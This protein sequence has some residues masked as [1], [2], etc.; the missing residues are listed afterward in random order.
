MDKYTLDKGV[1][2]IIPCL[3][4]E[5]YIEGLLK[6]LLKTSKNNEIIILDGGSQD[7]TLSILSR[8]KKRITIHQPRLTIVN[9]PKKTQASAINLGLLYVKNEICFRLDSHSMILNHSQL[10]ANISEIINIL[11]HK[12]DFCAIGFKQ[13]F[14]FENVIQASLFLLSL[15]P[16][17]SSTRSYRYAL[18]KCS[19][20]KTA[21]LFALNK[22]L[23][24][25]VNGFDESCIS[26]ED[27]DFNQKIIKYEKKPILIYPDIYIYYFPRSNIRKLWNQYYN[28]GLGRT[29]NEL[30][31]KEYS[32]GLGYIAVKI[33]LFILSSIVLI[34]SYLFIPYSYLF[35]ITTI[36]I[37]ASVQFL[38]DK[39]NFLCQSKISNIKILKLAIGLLISP[40]IATIPP[41]ALGIGSL[42]ALKKY[43][44]SIKSK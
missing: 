22:N 37:F 1:S 15:S 21:W 16:L 9:N 27:Y 12:K 35:L 40:I 32:K 7:R 23:A 36:L 26:N 17:L 4:E 14:S 33:L 6:T 43:I 2:F 44:L 31:N 41:L 29:K 3:N 38:F 24:N 13:R 11:T 18:R 10:N 28:Y 39:G 30:A 34:S 25:S 5:L 20:L 19:T 42:S 8:I